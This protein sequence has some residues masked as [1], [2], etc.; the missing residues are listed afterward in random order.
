MA[1]S[2]YKTAESVAD[3]FKEFYPD[4]IPLMPKYQEE[5]LTNPVG[6]LGTIFTEPWVFEDNFCLIG[7]AAHAFTPFFGQG[8]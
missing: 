3:F 5:F 6:F 8:I 7:D 4:A 2:K 1:F